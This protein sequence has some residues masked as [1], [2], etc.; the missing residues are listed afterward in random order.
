MITFQ[1]SVSETRESKAASEASSSEI[2]G[3]PVTISSL[4]NE[5]ASRLPALEEQSNG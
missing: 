4:R 5:S 3:T 1:K 2:G